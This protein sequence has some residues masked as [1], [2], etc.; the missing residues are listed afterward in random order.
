MGRQKSAFTT[1]RLTVNAVLI[2]LYVV[3][4]MFSIYIGQW[5]K[6]SFSALPLMV[7]ALLFGTVDG[8]IVAGLGEFLYQVFRY[9]LMP[10]TFMWIVPP[11]VHALIAGLVAGRMRSTSLARRTAASTVISGIIA[12]MITTVVIWLDGRYWGY[13]PG[14]TGIAIVLRFVNALIMCAVYTAV[15]PKVLPLLNQALRGAGRGR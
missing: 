6:L 2:A 1:R 8:V 3:L 14:L 12:A 5:I 11:I 13:D 9:G 10:T 15:L 4:D 7:A